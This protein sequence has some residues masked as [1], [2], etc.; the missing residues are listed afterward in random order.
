M[1][2]SCC[3]AH[4]AP[5][6]SDAGLAGCVCARDPFCCEVAWDALCASQVE[7]L[8]C[9]DC[10][11]QGGAGG[12]AGM[13][14]VAGTGGDGGSGGVRQCIAQARDDC[15]V[16]L[17]RGC[18]DELGACIADFGCPIILSCV[19]RTGCTGLGCYQPATCQGVID[20]FGGLTGRSMTLVLELGVCGALRSCDCG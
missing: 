17:C 15:E 18:F 8:G 20:A 19:E 14:G 11:G 13:G 2:G 7:T 5:S 16:C 1:P 6:C 9:G 4:A 3:E 12:V 10:G